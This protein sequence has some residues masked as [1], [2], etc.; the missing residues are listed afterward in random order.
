MH[1]TAEQGLG[2]AWVLHTVGQ[3]CLLGGAQRD[4]FNRSPWLH[5]DYPTLG[6]FFVILDSTGAV[7]ETMG[8]MHEIPD[9]PIYVPMSFSSHIAS[10]RLLHMLDRRNNMLIRVLHDKAAVLPNTLRADIATLTREN[11]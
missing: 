2:L 8:D 1:L 5:V 3:D 9:D 11:V 4:S 6:R 10:D 7:Y